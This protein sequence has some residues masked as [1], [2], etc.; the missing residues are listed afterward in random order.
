M[1]LAVTTRALLKQGYD[2]SGRIIRRSLSFLWPE[3][4]F[5]LVIF[6]IA[7]I[8]CLIYCFSWLYLNFRLLYLIN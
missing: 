1:S 4:I 7:T 3:G 2:N 5:C 6:A 8:F